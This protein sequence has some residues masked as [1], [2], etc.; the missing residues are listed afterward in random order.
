MNL[1]Y[2]TQGEGTPII[3]IHG[4]FGDGLNWGGVARQLK[5]KYHL[6]LP[7][8]RNHGRSG[9]D[10]NDC[11]Y[12]SMAEDVSGLMDELE[13]PDAHIV[14]HSM[15]GKIAMTLALSQ[16][17]RVRSL[18]VVDIAP[19]A[20]PE[21]HRDV[22]AGLSAV[23]QA[24]PKTRQE[25]DELLKPHLET[26]AIRTFILKNLE[27]D[28]DHFMWRLNW[29]ALYQHY[30]DLRDFPLAD[31]DPSPQYQGPTQFLV[32]GDSD[33]VS[34]DDQPVIKALFPQSKGRVVGGTGHWLH[35]EKPD[36]VARWIDDFIHQ[37][38]ATG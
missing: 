36:L 27:R 2:R 37:A 34:A 6:V 20:Y 12:P 18:T 24:Q 26:D 1:Y 14:G 32:G 23:A 11:T 7:D 19:K 10:N 4:L 13:L 17:E 15:G 3:I 5:D 9:H 16:P 21:G 30:A 33:Y 8:M 38:D 31:Q 25:A 22:F 29:E 28:G 35:A